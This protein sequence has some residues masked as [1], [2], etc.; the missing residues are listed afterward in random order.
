M[1][2]QDNVFRF[3]GAALAIASIAGASGCSRK[4]GDSCGISYVY[5][6]AAHCTGN[7]L[8]VCSGEGRRNS[9]GSWTRTECKGAAGCKER[10]DGPPACDI[11]GN[12]PGDPCAYN[13][14]HNN[15][16]EAC[17]AGDPRAKLHCT[18]EYVIE[19]VACPDGCTPRTDH[20]VLC[21]GRP[22]V[23]P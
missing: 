11:S 14:T 16:L 7:A 3:C 5:T 1:P 17:V 10:S 18:G 20:E 9:K 13:H 6:P 15:L 12:A 2:T 19:R 8:W 22:G 4:V 23:A 21:Q